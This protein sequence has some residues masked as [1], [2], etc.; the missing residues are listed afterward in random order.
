MERIFYYDF[1]KIEKENKRWGFLISAILHALILL[2]VLI[3]IFPMETDVPI[4][5][6][7]ELVVELL[8]P[9][10][11]PK[12]PQFGDG[13]GS[14]AGPESEVPK[15]GGSKGSEAAPALEEMEKQPSKVEVIKP[16][17]L[18]TNSSSKPILS[19]PETQVV[20]VE[21]PKVEPRPV[22]TNPA[23][24]TV[25]NPAPS[26]PSVPVI[27]APPVVT[28]TKPTQAGGHGTS[29]SS[30]TGDNDSPGGTGGSGS[31]SGNGNGSGGAN[32]GNGTGGGGNAGN[33]TGSGFGDGVGVNFDETGPLRRKV[34][35]RAPIGD[36][37]REYVQSAVFNICINQ[38]GKVSYLKYN[39]KLS[40]T[41][42]KS[43]IL[44]ATKK[45][46]QYE[47]MKDLS[48]P[49]KECGTFTFNID[50]VIYKMK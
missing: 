6:K 46:F 20:K 31:G 8:M 44:E 28:N 48:A 35:K 3:K 45:M 12:E 41:K 10:K 11:E 27:N 39:P 18:P 1:Y 23:P 9:V 7:K 34:S 49:K 36:L 26:K 50:G 15:E 13:G 42:D 25:S 21:A 37:A 14:S 38:E 29:G 19:A 32:S 22:P 16:T 24:V 33:G 47:F 5:E 2:L 40:K 30:S 43:F 4:V 17:P